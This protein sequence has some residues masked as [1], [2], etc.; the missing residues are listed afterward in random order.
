MRARPGPRLQCTSGPAPAFQVCQDPATCG[1]SCYRLGDTAANAV[2]APFFWNP[3][4]GVSVGYSNG[5]ACSI[6]AGGTWNT[7]NRSISLDFI[8]T[9]TS[10]FLPQQDAIIE[11]VTCRYHALI[12][13]R[14]GCP[15]ECPFALAPGKRGAGHLCAGQGVCDYDSN[16]QAARCFCDKGWSGFDCTQAGDKG[17]PPA[18]SYGGNIAGGF[19]GGVALGAVVLLLG[20]FIRAQMTRNTFSDA[21][22]FFNP[23]NRTGG[24]GG[25]SASYARAPAYEAGSADFAA[26][27][28]AFTTSS[29]APPEAKDGPLLA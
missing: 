16:A 14:S 2:V 13:S 10:G 12:Y 29:Y 28:P 24:G 19:F 11:D 6:N 9:D 22:N 5:D 15:L 1:N 27:P 25:A 4:H 20:V 26:P 3:S 21:L 17:L 23:V 7:R 18:V 8:C